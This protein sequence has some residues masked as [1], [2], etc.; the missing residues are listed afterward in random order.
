MNLGCSQS[1]ETPDN[2]NYRVALNL[3]EERNRELG[4][5]AALQRKPTATFK[6]RFNAFAQT[7]AF[8]LKLDLSYGTRDAAAV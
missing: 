4:I 7:S 6:V 5:A 1:S 3:Q 8:R 2:A